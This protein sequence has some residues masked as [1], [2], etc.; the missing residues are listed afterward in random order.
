MANK[1]VKRTPRLVRTLDSKKEYNGVNPL[2]LAAATLAGNPAGALL[3]KAA[4]ARSRNK[5]TKHK[6]K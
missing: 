3:V 2:H 6:Y 1:Q 5:A 4:K